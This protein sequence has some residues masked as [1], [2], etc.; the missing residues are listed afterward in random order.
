MNVLITGA[1]GFIGKKLA[2]RLLRSGTVLGRPLAELVLFDVVT[3][4]TKADAKIRCETGDIGDEAV[5]AKLFDRPIDA[6]FHLAAVV[7]A[8]AEADF[9]LGM[10]V[11]LRGTQLLLEA[12]R[13]AG[14]APRFL[15]A[16]SC[17]VYGG[18]LP[19]VITDLTHLNPQSSYGAQKAA[20]EL[21]VNDYGRKG[22]VD[23]RSLR[24][25]TIVVRPGRP[26]K[27]A[28]TFASSIVRE[29]LK[30]ETAVCPVEPS[31]AMYVLSPRRVVDAMMS[32]MELPA[33]ALG[34]NRSLL[35]PGR[36][37]TVGEML[38]ALGRVAGTSAVAR[39]Q[40]QLDPAIQRIVSS[41]PARFNAERAR[42]LGLRADDSL[43]DIIRQHL[44]DEHGGRSP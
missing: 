37:M 35:L 8:A 2:E 32:V 6:V 30:G 41:W 1:A 7:S 15:F 14:N 27:A 21:L 39:V 17:A 33:D 43:D 9:D 12:A 25:P 4:E 38:D 31:T 24:L 5:I 36:T 29:P 26:N 23:S 28:S 13:Q 20:G 3:P 42:S 44:E 19:E 34:S 16:S 10:R 11:N 40:F 22:F 18:T